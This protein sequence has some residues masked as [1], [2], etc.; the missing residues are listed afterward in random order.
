MTC[1]WKNYKNKTPTIKY[2]VVNMQFLFSTKHRRTFKSSMWD[3]SKILS[4]DSNS[5]F[6]ERYRA[7]PLSG[8]CSNLLYDPERITLTGLTFYHKKLDN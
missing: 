4:Q 5:S 6:V 2:L 7:V 3:T 1:A 8:V